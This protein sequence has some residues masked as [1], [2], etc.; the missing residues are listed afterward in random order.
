MFKLGLSLDSIAVHSALHKYRKR[1]HELFRVVNER[2]ARIMNFD[3]DAR[4]N[5]FPFSSQ[6]IT[7]N[8]ELLCFFCLLSGYAARSQRS[9]VMAIKM[10]IIPSGRVKLK[11]V[12]KKLEQKNIERLR[13]AS[14]RANY[15]VVLF[16]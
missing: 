11:A 9:L 7:I 15:L 4:K 3:L 12:R 10:V 13:A 8:T 1:A 6:V 5:F 14:E 2:R 16:V